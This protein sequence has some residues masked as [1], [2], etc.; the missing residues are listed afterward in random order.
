[1]WLALFVFFF[2]FF[3]LNTPFHCPSGCSIHFAFGNQPLFPVIS[4]GAANQGALPSPDCMGGACDPDL[5]IQSPWSPGHSSWFRDGPLPEAGSISVS[6][7]FCLAENGRGCLC[8]TCCARRLGSGAVGQLKVRGSS[9][10]HS[11]LLRWDVPS[12]FI[13][14]YPVLGT[15]PGTWVPL[16]QDVAWITRVSCVSTFLLLALPHQQQGPRPVLGPK[17]PVLSRTCPQEPASIFPMNH[18]TKK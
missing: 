3:G 5:T 15:V 2:F 11:W 12:W 4:V 17:G 16:T 1:M 10:T 13:P 6:W 14:I 8:W 18:R 7:D 9:V